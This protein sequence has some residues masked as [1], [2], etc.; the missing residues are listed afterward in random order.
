MN[1][2]RDIYV[3]A[4]WAGLEAATLMGILH[5]RRVRGAEIFSFEYDAD[6]IRNNNW[7]NLDPDLALFGGEQYLPDDRKTNFGI[8]SDSSPDRWGQILMKR[9]EAANASA[10]ERRP[11]ILFQTDFLLGVFDGHRMGALRFKLDPDESF[12]DDDVNMTTPPWTSIRELEDASLKL[13]TGDLA[14]NPEYRTWLNLLVGPGASLGGGR[15]K[16]S[17]KDTDGHLWIAKF[18]SHNDNGDQG[19]WEMLAYELALES[20]I[21][22]FECKMKKFTSN[23][24]TFITKRFDRTTEGRRIHFASAMTML[25]YP[26]GV[27]FVDGASYLDLVGF[28]MQHGARVDDDLEEL[29]KRITFSVCVSNTDDHLRNH[30]FML[31]DKGWILSPAYDINPKENGTGLILNISEDDN[32]LDLALVLATHKHY[33]LSEKKANEIISHI[34]KVV[35]TWKTKARKLG[36]S[37]V[38]INDKQTAF[39]AIEGHYS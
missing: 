32:R 14:N 8:F 22:M 9:R 18:P 19:A 11:E 4:D 7:S 12:L 31:S 21:N 30:G 36:I 34:A 16:A 24:H 39:L 10:E 26:D 37:G 28:L 15:P 3:Y 29:F 5:S 33:R 20:G 27:D 25:G 1:E 35:S 17:I 13:E 2:I 23:Y 38:E 6:W